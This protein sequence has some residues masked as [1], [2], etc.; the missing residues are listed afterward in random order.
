MLKAK[1]ILQ[2]LEALGNEK[3]HAQNKKRGASDNQFGVKMGDI[4]TLAKKIKTNHELALE[5][6]D[7]E[8]VDARFL[9]ILIIEPEKLSKD[10]I[11]KMVSSE[12]F[13]NIADWFYSYVIKDYSAKESLRQEWMHSNDIMHGRA[14]WSLTSGCV[15]RNPE[16]LDLPALLDRIETEMPNAAPEVQWTMNSTLAQIGIKFPEFRDRALSIGEKLGIYRDYPTS[17]GCTSPFA[18]IWI[19]EMVRRQE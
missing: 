16:V 8:N 6:W 1:D 14:A 5:L 18:P 11:A 12:K 4:R 10:Q 15:A 7:T 3:V 13:V 2:Q 9:A 19:N 17:K